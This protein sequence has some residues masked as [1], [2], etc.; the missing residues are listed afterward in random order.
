M[1]AIRGAD[2][3]PERIVRSFLHREG[4]R[5]RKNVKQLPGRP[6]VVLTKHRAVVF[7]HGCFWHQHKGCKRAT[8]PRS[9]VAFWVTKFAANKARDRR[10]NRTLIRLGWRV[11][12]VWECE[13]SPR[14]LLALKKRILAKEW[15]RA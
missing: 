2:T 4:L 14:T 15:R 1:S 5:F 8:Q 11:F 12:I 7:V 6:D 10:A 3:E 9:N 13:L